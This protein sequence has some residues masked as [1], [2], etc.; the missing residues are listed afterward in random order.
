MLKV[1][2]VVRDIG[3]LNT[4][5]YLVTSTTKGTMTLILQHDDLLI[6]MYEP[7]LIEL[8]F[9]FNIIIGPHFQDVTTRMPVMRI[10]GSKI[11]AVASLAI[12]A[13]VRRCSQCDFSAKSA[14]PI[15]LERA[16]SP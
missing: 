12:E 3:M 16:A 9:K 2:S 14:S 8:R 7:H 6:V 11:A 4:S 1:D 10:A 15:A 13:E 5:Y